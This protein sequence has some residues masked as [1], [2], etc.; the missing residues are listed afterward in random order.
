MAEKLPSYS[1]FWPYYLREHGRAR[2]RALHF[3]GTSLALICLILLIVT[4]NWWWLPAALVAGYLF[5]WIGHVFIEHNRPATFIHP[6]WS[7]ASDF[8]MY[9]LWVTGRL[10]GELRRAG[11][12]P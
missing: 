3:L 10:N 9:A 4:G 2:T 5:A 6:L 1:A 7:L 8:R 11:L 12:E